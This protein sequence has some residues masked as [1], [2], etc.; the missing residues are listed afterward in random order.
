MLVL[1][2]VVVVLQLLG[3]LEELHVDEEEEHVAADRLEE[4]QLV[5]GRDGRR[6]RQWRA[7]RA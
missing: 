5:G 4:E 1:R 2:I 7:A 6:A 3:L